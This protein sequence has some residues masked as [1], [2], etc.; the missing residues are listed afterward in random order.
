MIKRE[1][2]KNIVVTA[3]ILVVVCLIFFAGMVVMAYS[4]VTNV[5]VVD[6]CDVADELMSAEGVDPNTF[7]IRDWELYNTDVIGTY[8]AAIRYGKEYDVEVSN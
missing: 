4:V 7:T 5:E 8:L 6:L 2:I 1:T 3:S